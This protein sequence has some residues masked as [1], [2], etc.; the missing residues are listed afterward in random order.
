MQ[1]WVKLKEKLK[2]NIFFQAL[3]FAF[4]IAA[5]TFLGILVGF[6]LGKGWEGSVTGFALALFLSFLGFFIGLLISY[7]IVKRKYE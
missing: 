5:L 1:L 2:G 6:A 4:L 7:T 3:P